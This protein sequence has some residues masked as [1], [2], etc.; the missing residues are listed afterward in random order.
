MLNL[1]SWLV[2]IGVSTFGSAS[3]AVD[4]TGAG[5]TFPPE[6]RAAG[7][8]HDQLLCRDR[9]LVHAAGGHQQLQGLALQHTAEVASGAIAPAAAMDG[10]HGLAQLLGQGGGAGGCG[11]HARVRLA[12]CWQFGHQWLLRPPSLSR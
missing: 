7:I 1:K 4:I 6:H 2:A 12:Q 11:V 5:A 8:H 3:M 10:G 9:S